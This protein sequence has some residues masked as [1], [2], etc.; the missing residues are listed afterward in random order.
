VNAGI[1]V[2]GGT[3]IFNELSPNEPM[4]VSPLI[5]HHLGTT[6]VA[7]VLGMDL[8]TRSSA[9][10][11]VVMMN[12]APELGMPRPFAFYNPAQTP[13]QFAIAVDASKSRITTLRVRW[14]AI[15]NGM[16]QPT[17]VVNG[18]DRTT[19]P[20]AEPTAPERGTHVIGR[21]VHVLMRVAAEPGVTRT[22]LAREIG[23]TAAE[24]KPDLDRLAAG[25]LI[26]VAG[27]RIHPG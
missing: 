20:P 23:L 10:P 5:E 13:G 16:P 17:V 26:R 2:S 18:P 24:L 14:W 6:D 4:R 8:D 15:P 7:I 9:L 22:V 21:S 25:G 11:S 1:R 27:S 19:S 12:P 3:V